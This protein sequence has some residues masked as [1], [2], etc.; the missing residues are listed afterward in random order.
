M[1]A[2]GRVPRLLRLASMILNWN[3]L[4]L[5]A[6]G[7]VVILVCGHAIKVI[8]AR[9]NPEIFPPQFRRNAW[10]AAQTMI[11]HTAA[12]SCIQRLYGPD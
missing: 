12:P 11:A 2:E 9:H 1:R 8:E 7:L 5:F 3:M 10:W 6:L 4:V